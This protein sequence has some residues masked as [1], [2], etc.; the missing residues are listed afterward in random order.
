MKKAVFF[1]VVFTIVQF[2]HALASGPEVKKYSTFKH[3]SAGEAEGVAI[4]YDG[5][6]TLSPQFEILQETGVS[7]L[8]QMA[9]INKALFVGG[10][11]PATL[12]RIEGSDTT[13]VYSG[14]EAAVFALEADADG[15]LWFAPSPSGGV[16]RFKNGKAEKIAHLGVIYVWDLLAHDD[17]MLV[18]TGEPGYILSLTQAGEIDTFFVS[19]ETH[20]RALAKDES[21]NIYAGSAENGII[22]KF[23]RQGKPSVLYDSPQDEIFEIIPGENGVIWA[24][25]AKEGFQRPLTLPSSAQQS[26]RTPQAGSAGA[27]SGQ[28]QSAM[29]VDLPRPSRNN[30]AIY[31]ISSQGTAKSMWPR[32]ADRVQSFARKQGGGFVIGAGDDG[33]VYEM[34][35]D[36]RV[37]LLLDTDA[38]QIT[39]LATIDG[40]I[41]GVTANPGASVQIKPGA[42]KSGDYLS[43]VFDAKIHTRWGSLSS[44]QN[45]GKI[46][47]FTRSGN[48]A[49]PDKT[50]SDWKDLNQQSAGAQIQAPDAR[51]LQWKAVLQTRGGSAPKLTE[52]RFGYMQKNIAPEINTITIHEFGVSFPDA[53]ADGMKREL[54]NHRG[55]VNG[56]ANGRSSGNRKKVTMQG[57]QSVSW[58]AVD[59]NGDDLIYDVFYKKRTGGAWRPL[60]S[61]FTAGVYSWDSRTIE[62]G[63]YIV[64][65]VASDA[66][67]N[68]ASEA[69][70]A[71]KTSEP[72]R[73]DNTAPTITGL[74]SAASGKTTTVTFNVTDEG[75]RLKEAWYAIDASPWKILYSTDGILD[76]FSE[77]FSITFEN[78]AAGAHMLTIKVFDENDNVRFAHLNFEAK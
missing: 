78:L 66:P 57:F 58:N 56:A 19:E 65:V 69:E 32:D 73:V 60:V 62:D 43:K 40:L 76:A 39:Q 15:G 67:S 59:Q 17:K 27:G 75:A 30:G 61:E 47:F 8:W 49:E 18:A 68:Q 25:G 31:K 24:A 55:G 53:V 38:S 71:E 1:G 12:I 45:G 48:S 41:Y 77:S 74:K 13:S 20:I 3:F 14:K 33:R 63:E 21:G 11:D 22:Y 37:N 44:V 9:K 29:S 50:W 36:G 42:A 5:S 23:D 2:S 64:K 34:E 35:D 6:L 26:G 72:F 51:F 10:G 28:G 4:G 16:H 54:W 46:T 70:T 52:V 7:Q